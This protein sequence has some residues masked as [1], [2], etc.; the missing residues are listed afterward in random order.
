VA[1]TKLRYLLRCFR[2][3]P[4]S[5]SKVLRYLDPC[6][7][8]RA[9]EA[10]S[11]LRVLAASRAPQAS[12]SARLLLP[13]E[14]LPVLP[15]ASNLHKPPVDQLLHFKPLKLGR[16]TLHAARCTLHAAR[17]PEHRT[18]DDRSVDAV[19]VSEAHYTGRRLKTCRINNT[20]T[21]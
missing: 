18:I 13:S 10:S 12:L 19:L 11:F 6:T 8:Q 1:L 9:R 17:S 4:F 2:T 5:V 21:K 15:K 3:S 14:S 16:C 20:G 7:S